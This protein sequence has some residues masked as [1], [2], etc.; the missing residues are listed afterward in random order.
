[1][2]IDWI[3][4]YVYALITIVLFMCALFSGQETINDKMLMLV[5]AMMWPAISIVFAV[6]Y[7]LEKLRNYGRKY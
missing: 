5:M 6:F 2:D 1:M 3:V 7:I 4:L